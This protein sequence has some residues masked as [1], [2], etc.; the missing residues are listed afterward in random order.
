[1]LLSMRRLLKIFLVVLLLLQAPFLFSLYQSWR[2]KAYLQGLQTQRTAAPENPF[3]DM[4]GTIHV[5]SAA[6]SHS[7]GTYP[8]IIAAAKAAGYH[9]VFITEHTHRKAQL[10]RRLQDDELITIYGKEVEL[11]NGARILVSEEEGQPQPLTIV[12]ELAGSKLPQ[13][14]D[15]LEVFNLHTSAQQRQ[16]V[17]EWINLVYHQILFSGYFPF[18]VLEFDF[19]RIQA[20]NRILLTRHLTATGGNDAHQN[21]GLRMLTASGE[22]VFSFQVDPYEDSFRFLTNHVL[23]APTAE[24]N[25]AGL[26]RALRAGNSYI[27]LEAIADPT[28]FAFYAQRGEQIFGMGSRVPAGTQLIASSPLPVRFLFLRNGNPYRELEGYRFYL[29]PLEHGVY[30]VEVYPRNPPSLLEGKPWIISNPIYVE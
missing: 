25:A 20:W 12:S 17:F 22:E 5:H 1:M 16:N 10:F 21:I 27:A 30:R 26:L 9:Y 29:N 4:R 15:A 19:D 23:L 7:L 18:H 2:V 24:L 28:G 13:E 6:G 14:A 8:E 11:E 3:L